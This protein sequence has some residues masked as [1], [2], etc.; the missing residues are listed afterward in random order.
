M[1]AEMFQNDQTVKIG[2]WLIMTFKDL[3]A[4]KGAVFCI[5][6]DPKATRSFDNLVVNYH[7]VCRVQSRLTETALPFN[8]HLITLLIPIPQAK[9]FCLPLLVRSLLESAEFMLQ[10]SKTIRIWRV[11]RL[12][13]EARSACRG[14]ADF[15][16]EVKG[17]RIY[18]YKN[19]EIKHELERRKCATKPRNY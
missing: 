1:L 9:D 4:P 8:R 7:V 18:I 10:C 14:E 13:Q 19:I 17:R 12:C 11:V 2:L 6:S 16:P 5:S 3:V 15:F